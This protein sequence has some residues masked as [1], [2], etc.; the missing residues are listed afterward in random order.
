MEFPRKLL[1][2][3]KI[4]LILDLLYIN[5]INL[6]LSLILIPIN[7]WIIPSYLN[8]FSIII[9]NLV[10]KEFIYSSRFSVAVPHIIKHY[11]FFYLY[12]NTL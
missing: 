2:I 9:I 8:L 7:Y 11:I 12:I 1:F 10:Y 5:W 4:S 3:I 6:L